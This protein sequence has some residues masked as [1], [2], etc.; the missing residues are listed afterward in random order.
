MNE[1]TI[2][3]LLSDLQEGKVSLS[4]ALE[5]LKNLP[6]EDIGFA[7]IDHHRGL[8]RGYGEVIFG[9]GKAPDDIVEIMKRMIE[10]GARTGLVEGYLAP[11]LQVR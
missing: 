9:E 4:D 8:R 3:E 7:C 6:F 10:Q 1:D 5:K 11:H 2:R